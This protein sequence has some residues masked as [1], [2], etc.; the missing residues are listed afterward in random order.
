MLRVMLALLI[1]T[2]TATAAMPFEV[3]AL[4]IPAPQI[5]EWRPVPR[6][7]PKEIQSLTF[8]SVLLFHCG[9]ALHF[10]FLHRPAIGLIELFGSEERY[11]AALETTRVEVVRLALRS[12]SAE[13]PEDYREIE[14]LALDEAQTHTLR[15][16]LTADAAYVWSDGDE[17]LESFPVY[18]LRIRLWQGEKALTADFSLSA[19]TIR[20]IENYAIIAEQPLSEYGRALLE[21]LTELADARE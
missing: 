12:H 17:I 10:E 14:P 6:V 7:P 16:A 8:P 4:A 9:G 21:F 3:P 15:H 2:T 20:I 18:D 1:V 11:R 13:K 5:P 19:Q